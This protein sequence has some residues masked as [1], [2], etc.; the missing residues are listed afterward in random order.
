M[1][2]AN[3]QNDA[4]VRRLRKRGKRIAA[5]QAERVRQ[6][7]RIGDANWHSAQSLWPNFTQG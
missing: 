1:I 3:A 5:Q 2:S 7:A 6:K 4:L